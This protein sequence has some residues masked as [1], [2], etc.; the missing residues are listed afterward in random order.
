[1]GETRIGRGH[2][3]SGELTS[4]DDLTVHGAIDG[5]VETAGRVLVER[6]ARVQGG[7]LGKTVEVSGTIEGPVRAAER[8]EIRPEGTVL[9]DIRAPR[10]LI[11]DGARFQGNVH[12]DRT[13]SDEAGEE[14]ES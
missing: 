12:M 7:V 3:V 5:N 11:S 6:R 4:T 10:I 8:I 14:D 1:M 9:G 13:T 2:V